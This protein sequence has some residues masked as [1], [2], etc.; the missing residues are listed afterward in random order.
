MLEEILNL[1][2]DGNAVASIDL[3]R[4]FL[5]FKNPDPALA[6]RAL[7]GI[8]GKDRRFYFGSD[9]LWHGAAPVEI[10]PETQSLRAVS[11]RCVHVL[12]GMHTATNKV[13]H[14]SV[15]NPLPDAQEVCQEW[16]EPPDLLAYDER[17]TLI[18]SATPVFDENKK[19]ERLFTIAE[20]CR[21]NTA[22]FVSFDQFAR[23]RRCASLAG[24]A[25]PEEVF[26]LSHFFSAAQISLP[27][28]LTLTACYHTL[29]D[30]DPV[31]TN[32]PSYGA[33]LARCVAE[34]LERLAGMGIAT[35]A[36]LENEL[37]KEA[38][39]FDFSQKN[40]T[41]TTLRDLPRSPGVYAFTKKTGEYLYIG[42]TTNLRRRVLGYFRQTDESPEKL[43]RLRAEAYG[44][45]THV[46]G[47]E[48]ESLI[49]E[50]RLIRKYAPTLNSKIDINERKGVFKPLND[51]IILLPHAEDDKGMSFWFRKNQKIALKPFSIDFKDGELLLH[52]LESFFFSDTLA[53]QPTDFPEQEIAQRWIKAHQ[54]EL[55]IVPVFGMKDAKEILE[56]I[57]NNWGD[58]EHS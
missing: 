51:C 19:T 29:F 30:R 38:A 58:V 37:T 15:W 32:A 43:L 5:K 25:L 4:D 55:I 16:L 17:T 26:L 1:L 34:I 18:S 13:F 6:H 57:K 22:V 35:L 45:T 14:V 7:A 36:D 31:L 46:C 54:E 28:P 9:G 27:K 39:S 33:A 41:F 50:Y 21:E 3:A 48:L 24:I 12:T 2:R 23:L 47:S 53:A 8:L 52:E 42:K 56:G 44:L 49:Y 20:Q 11:W 10:G 40:F